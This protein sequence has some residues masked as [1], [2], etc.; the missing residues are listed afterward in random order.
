MKKQCPCIRG[1]RRRR[2]TCHPN[3]WSGRAFLGDESDGDGG[4]GD[5]DGA[6]YCHVNVLSMCVCLFIFLFNMVNIWDNM[7]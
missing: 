2:V 3:Q 1:F 7:G 5:G 4:D 6:L